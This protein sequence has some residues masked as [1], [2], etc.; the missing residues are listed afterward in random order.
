[1]GFAAR[2]QVG[3]RA[4]CERAVF[5]EAD[6]AHQLERDLDQIVRGAGQRLVGAEP[7]PGFGRGRPCLP[8]QR[9]FELHQTLLDRVLPLGRRPP[10]RLRDRRREVHLAAGA[11]DAH[12]LAE[13]VG[14]PDRA[15]ARDGE[16]FEHAAEIPAARVATGPH[17]EA[18]VGGGVA[19]HALVVELP[20]HAVG[21]LGFAPVRDRVDAARRGVARDDD[22]VRAQELDVHVLAEADE[23]A[24]CAGRPRGVSHFSTPAGISSRKRL[25]TL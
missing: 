22:L 21:D 19:E 8:R 23:P 25:A 6:R 1:M 11:L 14:E 3:E 7:A 13:A 16:G 17:A 12:L 9:L 24:R 10:H 15:A 2:R 20:Q 18:Q 4:L 5:V